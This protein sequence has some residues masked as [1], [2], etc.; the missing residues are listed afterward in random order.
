VALAD[1]GGSV[2]VGDSTGNIFFASPDGSAG[3]RTIRGNS[4][5]TALVFAPNSDLLVSG[6][7][8]GDVVI[9]DSLSLTAVDGA[10]SFSAPIRWIASE[11]DASVLRV[12]SGG[13]VHVVDRTGGMDRVTTS[14]LLPARL[15]GSPSLALTRRGT[16]R[17]L[18][19]AGGGQLV[20]GELDLTGARAGPRRE[21]GEAAA[22]LALPARNWARVLGIELDPVSGEVIDV[23]F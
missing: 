6:S 4:P 23:E 10:V 22:A 16:L 11:S 18:A 2:A 15:R 14:R 13:W 5:I 8:S 20:F 9:W 21:P 19:N 12:Q 1:D 3:Y 17:A 7:E